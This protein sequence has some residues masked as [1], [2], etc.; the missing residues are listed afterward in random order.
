MESL[1]IWAKENPIYAL[2]IGVILASVL[3]HLFS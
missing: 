1:K 3:Y 2:I